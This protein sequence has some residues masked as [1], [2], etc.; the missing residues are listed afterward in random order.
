M[1]PGAVS[2]SGRTSLVSADEYNEPG[3]EI[4]TTA[5]A[6]VAHANVLKGQGLHM[7]N[8]IVPV[9]PVFVRLITHQNDTDVQMSPFSPFLADFR[10]I[11][12]F[13]SVLITTFG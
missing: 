11:S 6:T 4:P 5:L 3:L 1:R 8:A 7:Q 2:D 9:L 12:H 10:K 13:Y